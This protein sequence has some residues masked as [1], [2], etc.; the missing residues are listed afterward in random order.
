MLLGLV[1]QRLGAGSSRKVL[2][3]GCGIGR[4]D[5]ELVG[6]VGELHDIDTSQK[7]L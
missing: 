3:V 6:G 4:V 7:S 1:E 2:D 5:A